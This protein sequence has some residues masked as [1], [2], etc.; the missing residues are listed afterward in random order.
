MTFKILSKIEVTKLVYNNINIVNETYDIYENATIYLTNPFPKMSNASGISNGIY[1]FRNEEFI[2]E[3]R[4]LIV[5]Y[6]REEVESSDDIEFHFSKDIQLEDD[7]SYS[8]AAFGLP[9]Y[10]SATDNYGFEPFEAVL[11]NN[12][13]SLTLSHNKLYSVT[14]EEYTTSIPEYT[15]PMRGCVID[16]SK[17]IES[18]ETIDIGD[19][20]VY[21][22]PYGLWYNNSEITSDNELPSNLVGTTDLQYLPYCQ[23]YLEQASDGYYYVNDIENSMTNNVQAAAEILGSFI[24]IDRYGNKKLVDV[25]N[26]F[27]LYPE[28]T[29]YP[30]EN[31]TDL[32]PSDG[33]GEIAVLSDYSSVWFEDYEC[34]PYGKIYV[35]Y[36]N[37]SGN[38]E[39]LKYT[40]DR[41]Y[42]N[43]YIMND[44]YI[45]KNG[46][47]KPADIREIINRCFIPKLRFIRY[48][49]ANLE[50]L[51]LP[52]LEAGDCV[53]VLTD[54]GGVEVFM[55]RRTLS[56][57]QYL[58]DSIEVDGDEYTTYTEDSS[59][60]SIVE[61]DE[62]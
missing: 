51:G 31:D 45:F 23:F 12:S 15:G 62:T 33:T 29:L 47:W 60:T 34:Q 37:T 55:L 25:S 39:L 8:L 53:Q 17:T 61:V 38:D 26:N 1:H 19:Y 21:N 3:L 4:L 20:I 57:E 6:H 36:K 11:K 46:N 52:Y 14:Y 13:D 22:K 59:T 24:H 9:F 18:T 30:E 41:R 10:G 54:T 42:D 58:T 49:P 32:Y 16:S 56:G 44:N 43:V 35:S 40:F 2:P 7:V 50:M 27:A 5:Y 48:T 28:E